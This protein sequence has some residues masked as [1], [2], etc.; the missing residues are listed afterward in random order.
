MTTNRVF[1]ALGGSKGLTSLALALGLGF[2]AM[3]CDSA[4]T[5]PEPEA[6]GGEGILCNVS[7][8]QGEAGYGKDG[9]TPFDMRHYWPVDVTLGT[10]GEVFIVD[11][12]NH[13]VRKI[14]ADGTTS[15]FIGISTL[16]DESTGPA[17]Q[18]HLNHPSN[19]TIGPDGDYYLASWHNWKIKLI[20]KTT[21]QTSAPVGTLQ[22]YEGD[23]G[24]AQM[25]RMDLPAAVVF[26]FDGNMYIADQGNA[27]IRIVTPD[28]MIDTFVGSGQR[29]FADGVGSEASFS[30]PFGPD[31]TPGGKIAIN[32]DRTAIYLADTKNNRIRKI[33]IATRMVTTIAGTG[34]AGYSGDGGSA[35]SATLNGPTDVYVSHDQDIYFADTE[36]HVIRKIDVAGNIST[37]VG[38][39]E[40]GFS[41]DA[42]PA[43]QAKLNRPFGITYDE[44]NHTLYI[45]DTFNQQIKRVE[46]DHN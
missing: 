18:L 31:A 9:L 3:G 6:C 45:A 41:D 34:A 24:P 29:A 1:K 8:A 14:A 30:L 7:G 16:G 22:G 12:N 11:W 33:D 40:A 42:T 13:V 15:R 28:G 27:R 20:D 38:T 17:D 5:E 36:N 44:G 25:A 19:L 43:L 21:M 26:D 4:S 37:V 2:A 39:G 23:G 10:A 35:V 32:D 46:L